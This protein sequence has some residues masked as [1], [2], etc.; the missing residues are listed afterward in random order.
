VSTSTPD[1]SPAGRRRRRL[2]WAVVAVIVALFPV[3][4]LLV[5][6]TGNWVAVAQALPFLTF[7]IVGAVLA[8]KRPSNPLGW[9]MLAIGFVWV[10]PFELYADYALHVRR[11][12]VPGGAYA[13]AIAGPGWVPFIGLSGFMLLLFPD[14]HVPSPRWR[15]LAW[16]CGVGL[17][18]LFLVI[19]FSPGRFTESGYPHVRNPLG[20]EAL[21]P[22]FGPALALVASAPL[23]VLG[24][25]AAVVVRMRRSRDDVERHQLRWLA[26][27]AAVIAVLYLLAFVPN[28]FLS[29]GWAN[30][31]GNVAVFAF[32]LIP[33]T[34]GIAVL[35]YRLYD[36]DVVIRKTVIV[37]AIAVFF[38]VVYVAIVG[39]I[40]ALVQ[41]HSTTV[42]SFVAAAVVAALFQPVLGASR[43]IADRMVYG[44]RATPYE[45]LAAFGGRL[46]EAYATEDVLG[47]MAQILASGGG[48]TT[49]GVW[50]RVGGELRPAAVWPPDRHDV[51]PLR[52]RDD[53]VAGP[54]EG[55]SVEVRDAGELLGALSVT[56][57][58]NDPM[59]AEKRKLVLDL[60]SQ[61]GLVLRNVRLVEE[62]RASQRRLVAAQDEE[63]RRLERNIHD[64]AQQQL[65]ALAVK[66][67]LAR[68][69]VGRDDEKTG[70]MLDQIGAETQ[71]AL[72]DLRDLARGIYPPLLADKGLV[73]A[74]EAQARKAPVPVEISPDG[75]GRYPQEVE[76]AVYFSVLEALQNTAKY[77]NASRVA[78]RL[79]QE[80]GYLAFEVRDDGGGF[81][82]GAHGYGTG[83]QGI[84]DRLA[85]LDGAFDVRSAPGSGTNVRGK[86]RVG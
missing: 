37:A 7:P 83:L 79:A 2:A 77:A 28:A 44:R 10:L 27:T 78:V 46:G 45:V 1:A 34:I 33:V 80:D 54:I 8:L 72:E 24:G 63:R 19:L 30:A 76:A 49:A 36:I 31:F 4:V 84:A 38:T 20:V 82:P 73:A 25:A 18:L 71:D 13:L 68:S 29:V 60:A 70:E 55:S 50:L 14:G 74:L 17:S 35:R 62:L 66:A 43:R 59:T 39:G 42:L 58:A 57:P 6:L 40:G 64:G 47:R 65:V 9:L 53:A 41:A 56:M 11:G 51:A 69:L 61:A 85:A 81:D 32:A 12:A 75:I 26:W 48:A 15:W 52:V 86:V 5:S 3:N 23:I 67:R 21:R 16:G 22:F